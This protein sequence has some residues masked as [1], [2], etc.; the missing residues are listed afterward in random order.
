MRDDRAMRLGECPTRDDLLEL[1]EEP[2]GRRLKENIRSAA[3][4]RLKSY[5]SYP[6]CPNTPLVFIHLGGD[7]GLTIPSLR[8]LVRRGTAN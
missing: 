8:P 1:L 5:P 7:E 4:G 6:S 2:Y 3:N